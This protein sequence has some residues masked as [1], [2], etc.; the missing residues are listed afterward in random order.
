MAAVKPEA[1]AVEEGVAEAGGAD[2]GAGTGAKRP[3]EELAAGD[4]GAPPKRKK[5][6]PKKEE[7]VP[8]HRK[9]LLTGISGVKQ[10]ALQGQLD[11]SGIPHTKLWKARNKDAGEIWLKDDDVFLKVC[12][13]TAPSPQC[14]L[15]AG[16]HL[17]V[18]VRSQLICVCGV[19]AG[20]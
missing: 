11:R 20:L 12:L 2:T 15:T 8:G 7:P 14:E 1:G 4:G 18:R 5:P 10:E 17:L 6:E 19:C 3:A 16:A 13:L 9:F